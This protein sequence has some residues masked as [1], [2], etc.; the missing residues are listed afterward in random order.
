[1]IRCIGS[2][3]V[4]LFA[5]AAEGTALGAVKL[6][7]YTFDKTLKIALGAGTS[8]LVKFDQSYAYGEKED[9]DKEN[10]DVAEKYGLKKDDF[11]VYYLFNE[12][13][14]DGLKYTGGIKA[15]E[16]AGW[17]RRNKVKMPAVGTID[18]LDTIAKAFMKEMTPE[19][20]TE[21]KKLA[22]GDYKNDRKAAMYVK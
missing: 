16:I 2:L 15:D 11:P 6:D 21:A 17:L 9:G 7:N 14:K 1:M 4:A 10:S 3:A 22:D 5:V 13:N 8:F 20:I 18:E 12:A 19:K